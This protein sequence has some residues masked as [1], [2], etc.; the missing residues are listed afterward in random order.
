MCLPF[1][2]KSENIFVS[3]IIAT[4]GRSMLM[5]LLIWYGNLNMERNEKSKTSEVRDYADLKQ[6]KLIKIILIKI[7]YHNL[8]S[9]DFAIFN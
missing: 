5:L 9:I 8:R 7:G 2:G 1:W 4:L 6:T 3:V